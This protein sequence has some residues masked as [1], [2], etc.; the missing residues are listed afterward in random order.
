MNMCALLQPRE[1]SRPFP[2]IQ[3]VSEGRRRI[4]R[5]ERKKNERGGIATIQRRSASLISVLTVVDG[6]DPHIE[7][8]GSYFPSRPSSFAM[9]V[10]LA[11]SPLRTC[12][13]ATPPLKMSIVNCIL[14]TGGSPRLRFRNVSGFIVVILAVLNGARKSSTLTCLYLSEF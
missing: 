12:Q 2:P 8:S 10:M 9:S 1:P 11:N 13:F 4:S 6:L 7:Y 3:V 14:D 5:D